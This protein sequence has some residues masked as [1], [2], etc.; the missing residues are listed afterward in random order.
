MN[1]FPYDALHIQY[2]TSSCLTVSDVN[3]MLVSLIVVSI[4]QSV[5]II[6]SGGLKYSLHEVKTTFD[7]NSKKQFY[8]NIFR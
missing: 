6:P 8:I 3:D 1:L 4:Y 5:N 2:L 7:F